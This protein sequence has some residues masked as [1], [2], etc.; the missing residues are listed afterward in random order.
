M[1]PLEEDNRVDNNLFCAY[2]LCIVTAFSKFWN[3]MK[4]VM[5]W[6]AEYPATIV[7]TQEDYK[8]S[9][10][11]EPVT[12]L[13]VQISHQGLILSLDMLSKPV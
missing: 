10:N 3:K 5:F 1:Y 13:L 12:W 6:T 7:L 4:R 9:Q 11:T 2:E 8:D